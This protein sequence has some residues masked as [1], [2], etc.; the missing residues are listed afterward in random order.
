MQL[1]SVF[2][3]LREPPL[4][5]NIDGIFGIVANI[6]A[7]LKRLRRPRDALAHPF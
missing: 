5:V 2:F 4:C 7:L 1:L 3:Q 6:E